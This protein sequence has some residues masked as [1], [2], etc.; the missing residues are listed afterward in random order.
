MLILF[1][2]CSMFLWVDVNVYIILYYNAVAWA[3]FECVGINC[4]PP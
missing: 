2:L 4:L 1:I 3:G